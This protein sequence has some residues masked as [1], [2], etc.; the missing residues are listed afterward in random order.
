MVSSILTPPRPEAYVAENVCRSRTRH[1]SAPEKAIECPGS[2]PLYHYS[3][4]RNKK[5]K[6]QIAAA[7]GARSGVHRF[8]PRLWKRLHQAYGRYQRK[9]PPIY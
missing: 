6:R 9:L 5:S 3:G 2:S 8:D 1:L 7:T 4:L